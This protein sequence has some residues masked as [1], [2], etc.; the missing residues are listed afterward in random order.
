MESI[1]TRGA[2][3]K[4]MERPLLFNQTARA[5]RVRAARSW[6]LEPKMGQATR[7]PFSLVERRKIR[8]RTRVATVE[9]KEANLPLRPVSSWKMYLAKRV[10]TSKVS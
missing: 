5:R 3:T 8:G 1:T 9:R 6:L 4:P 2:T 10:H 7:Y